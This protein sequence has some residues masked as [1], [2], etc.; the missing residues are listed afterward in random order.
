[1]PKR[2]AILLGIAAAVVLAVLV[3]AWQGQRVVQ[4]IEAVLPDGGGLREGSAV[5]YRGVLV[6]TV[7]R[8]WFDDEGVRMTLGLTQPV[9][10]RRGDTLRVHTLGLLGD[11]V[12]DIRPGPA[13]APLLQPGTLLRGP[14]PMSPVTTDELREL[15]T[16][17]RP[18]GSSDSAASRAPRP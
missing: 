7:E 12:A 18:L 6:G 10:V 13:S 3:A 17:D 16:R 14:A 5:A 4:R 15:L 9:P 8:M 2:L 1:M 11:R